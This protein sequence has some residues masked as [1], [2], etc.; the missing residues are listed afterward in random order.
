MTAVG[1]DQRAVARVTVQGTSTDQE[2]F[3][4]AVA[5]RGWVAL[6]SDVPEGLT[7][8]VAGRARYTVEVRFPGSP[9]RAVNGA[10][11]RLEVLA[12]RLKLELTVTAVDLV[13]G[14]P[15]FRLHW[16][17][18]RPADRPHVAPQVGPFERLRRAAAQMW[19][20]G[21]QVRADTEAEALALAA[22]PLPGTAAQPADAQ[23]RLRWQELFG[24]G[25]GLGAPRKH[26]L[27]GM[28]YCSVVLVLLG[29]AVAQD[30]STSVRQA[31]FWAFVLTA[32][33]ALAVAA[34]ILRRN[35]PGLPLGA[36]AVP[37]AAIC[38]GSFLTGLIT[39]Q[40]IAAYAPDIFSGGHA[41][42]ILLAGLLV[43]RR[44]GLLFRHTS[45][46][47]G[48][49]WLLPAVLPFIPGVLPSAGLWQATLYLNELNVD[50][51]DVQ[52]PA[53][54]QFQSGLAVLGA[55]SLWLIAPALLGLAQHL[56]FMVRERWIGYAAFALLSAWGLL[57]GAWN[58]AYLPAVDAG[59]DASIAAAEGKAV[60][61][62]YGI[63]PVWVCIL[64]VG[65]AQKVPVDGGTLDPALPY[66]KVGD[67][68]G[69]AVLVPIGKEPV[70]V[71][72]ASVRLVPIGTVP[73]FHTCREFT[74][75]AQNPV[76]KV[77][78]GITTRSLR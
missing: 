19:G 32:L 54:D 65:S 3:T 67:A 42:L 18:F 7:A 33:A 69:T 11:Q 36:L 13:R 5:D 59:F 28:G 43:L 31:R 70:K 20:T 72:M 50:V 23:V 44:L 25:P 38:T 62:G 56:H 66:L 2:L 26:L 52:I 24:H 27:A 34:G 75:V 35:R 58:F 57:V 16:S 14:E 4:S 12:E 74:A 71:R 45:L 78:S 73:G 9:Y 49:P 17:V 51:E 10:R 29:V 63:D 15:D 40:G 6:E 1:W 68:D 77:A 55:M 41:L 30:D 48:L 8:C 60:P 53:W 61:A 64:P 22:T 39:G 76:F 46:R 21:R 37:L 47:G